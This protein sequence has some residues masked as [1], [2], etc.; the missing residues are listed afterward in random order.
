M[1]QGRTVSMSVL[2]L[3]EDKLDYRTLSP[4][5]SG[6][7][8]SYVRYT[9][10]REAE[11]LVESGETCCHRPSRKV[12]V[13]PGLSANGVENEDLSSARTPL[14]LN[15]QVTL[16]NGRKLVPCVARRK[17]QHRNIFVS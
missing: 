13:Y 14:N 8:T 12:T 5:G 11:I 16:K 7:G 17:E 9:M 1:A 6:T 15:L 2:R 3:L 4:L 10:E